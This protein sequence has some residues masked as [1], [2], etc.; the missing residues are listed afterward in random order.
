MK[1]AENLPPF[2]PG[3]APHLI[4]DGAA[5]A[6]EFYKKAFDAEEMMRLPAPDGRLMHAAV[7]VNGC[8]VMLMDEFRENA[9]ALGPKALNGT[10]VVLH[11]AVADVDAVFAQ[12][13][14]AGG[15]A[16]LSPTD[17]FWGDRYGQIEDPFGHLWSMATPGA[18]KSADE[19]LEASRNAGSCGEVSA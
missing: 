15:K 7:S 12:A 19:I 11:L 13:V 3:L 16:V 10:P 18:P 9:K 6:I 14:A 5:D 2:M 17:M 8:M 1:P 4:C